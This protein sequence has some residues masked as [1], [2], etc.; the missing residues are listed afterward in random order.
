MKGAP[1]LAAT[2]AAFLDLSLAGGGLAI[3]AASPSAG[4]AVAS[5]TTVTVGSAPAAIV[6]DSANGFVYVAN[7]NSSSVSVINGTL[8]ACDVGGGVRPNR[9]DV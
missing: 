3:L 5:V 4:A 1:L 9:L 7:S 2:C 6:L 8:A